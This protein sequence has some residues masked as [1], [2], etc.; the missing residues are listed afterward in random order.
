MEN[1]LSRRNWFKST[2]A[3]SAGLAL[4]GLPS[5]QAGSL[6]SRLE[7]APLSKA[8]REF[9][10]SKAP[11]AKVRLNSNENPYGPSKK[12]KEAVVQILNE[13]N[14]YQFQTQEELRKR[15]AQRENID[16]S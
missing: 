4:T 3:M 16:P 15:I 12:A 6:V 5:V 9:F 13:A 7:A 14:R 1:H 8:E 11:G 2:F 10:A